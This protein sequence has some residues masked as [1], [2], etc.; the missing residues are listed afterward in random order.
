MYQWRRDKPL[1]EAP[2]LENLDYTTSLVTK[3][4]FSREPKEI[5]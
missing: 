5:G 2:L 1:T 4:F 3:A